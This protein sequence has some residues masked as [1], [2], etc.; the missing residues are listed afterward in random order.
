[1][2]FIPHDFWMWLIIRHSQTHS[3]VASYR[4][5]I[6]EWLVDVATKVYSINCHEMDVPLERNTN[7]S[8]IWHYVGQTY[9]QHP[10]TLP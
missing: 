9:N 3:R 5:I 7:A 8:W 6:S 10:Y 1:M 4:A 2:M